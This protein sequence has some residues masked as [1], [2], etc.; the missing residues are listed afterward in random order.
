VVTRWQDIHIGNILFSH[1]PFRPFHE[2]APERDFR[3]KAKVAYAFID[4][5][6]AYDFSGG[7]PPFGTPITVPPESVRAPEQTDPASGDIDLFAADVYNLGKVLGIELATAL[8]VRWLRMPGPFPILTETALWRRL[9][10]Q[11]PFIRIW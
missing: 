2:R 5:G 10:P 9:P 11:P 1:G 3:L 6:S 4:F 7:T 8:E